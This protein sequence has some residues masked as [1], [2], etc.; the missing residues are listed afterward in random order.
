MHWPKVSDKKKNELRVLKESLRTSPL[1][2]NPREN[3]K[4]SE[5]RDL[6]SNIGGKP[7]SDNEG[8]RTAQVRRKILWHK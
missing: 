3:R 4:Q 1:K 2:L 7:A 6:V 8:E 5:G